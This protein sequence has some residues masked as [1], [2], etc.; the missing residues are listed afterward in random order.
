LRHAY[1]QVD[2]AR[3]WEIATGDLLWMAAAVEAALQR[4]DKAQEL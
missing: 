1:G 4:L 2:P 3:I